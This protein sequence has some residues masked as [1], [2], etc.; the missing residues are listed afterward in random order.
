MT[1]EHRIHTPSPMGHAIHVDVVCKRQLLRRRC[2][3]GRQRI[4]GWGCLRR[5]RRRWSWLRSLQLRHHHR[6]WDDRRAGRQM[7]QHVERFQKQTSLEDGK[8]QRELLS[9]GVHTPWPW[10]I[11]TD[12]SQRHRVFRQRAPRITVEVLADESSKP[13]SSLGLCLDWRAAHHPLFA[14]R[15][16]R[17]RATLA[18]L[19]ETHSQGREQRARVQPLIGNP[20]PTHLL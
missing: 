4:Y 16:R 7:C 19:C 13:S 11:L 9:H 17:P 5:R 18:L 15:L 14:P 3:G 1:R 20:P 10:H 12:C 2:F 8:A 6:R